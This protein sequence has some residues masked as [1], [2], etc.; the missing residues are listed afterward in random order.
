MFNDI[1]SERA[2]IVA[3]Y[4]IYETVSVIIDTRKAVQLGL[5]APHVGGKVRMVPLYTVVHNGHNDSR[6]A[7]AQ[8][9]CS[10]AVDIRP[11]LDS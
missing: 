6:V 7:G 2:K 1:A 11:F 8:L 10:P 9:P 4:V 3:V 5:V